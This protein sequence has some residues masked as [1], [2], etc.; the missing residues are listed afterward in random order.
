MRAT[1]GAQP[2]TSHVLPPYAHPVPTPLPALCSSIDSDAW[3]SDVEDSQGSDTPLYLTDDSAASRRASARLAGALSLPG[4]AVA[5]AAAALEER[6]VEREP[7][8]RAA[9]AASRLKLSY[10]TSQA[11]LAQVCCL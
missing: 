3:R 7:S 2:P 11:Q 8:V 9:A 6:A 1:R 4:A 5:V 10:I